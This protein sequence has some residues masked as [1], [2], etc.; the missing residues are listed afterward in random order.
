MLSHDIMKQVA[1][2]AMSGT[3]RQVRHLQLYD[4]LRASERPNILAIH[5][6]Q[7]GLPHDAYQHATVAAQEA[8]DVFA[9]AE[10]HYYSLMAL[11]HARPGEERRASLLHVINLLDL[12]DRQSDSLQYIPE[13][14]ALC[15]EAGDIHGVVLCDARNIFIELS[16]RSRPFDSLWADIKKILSSTSDLHENPAT[17]TAVLRV[18]TFSHTYTSDPTQLQEIFSFIER[19]VGYLPKEERA[20]GLADLG[21]IAAYHDPDRAMSICDEAVYLASTAGTPRLYNRCLSARGS[22][23]M[24]S[25]DYDGAL[26]DFDSAEATVSSG[27][28]NILFRVYTNRACIHY[29]RG[30]WEKGNE[31][32]NK[33][34]SCS[35]RENFLPLLNKTSGLIM[36]GLYEEAIRICRTVLSE[37][38]SFGAAWIELAARSMLGWALLESNRHIEATEQES[39]IIDLLST[40]QIVVSDPSYT[41]IF[42]AKMQI[43]RADLNAARFG[44]E[45]ELNSG[46]YCA[47]FG[48]CRMKIELAK[49]VRETDSDLAFH[50][51]R[52]A[53]TDAKRAGS[54]TLEKQA[55][56][57][58]HSISY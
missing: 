43:W 56:Q 50:Y 4:A 3:I 28:S 45:T 33:A 13:C 38:E 42:R 17:V 12:L 16:Q 8:Q 19:W 7:A 15:V 14:R 36:V 21:V 47:L 10:A 9:Y 39:K 26:Q 40:Q 37:N 34:I 48:R 46:R 53:L 20:A 1:Y 54:T 49:V 5:C 30:E 51:A 29:G 11:E 6:D 31:E 27:Y 41:V 58:L 52:S 25:G 57:V 44:L 22:A 55:N 18:A 35:S 2:G 23:R 32:T 24:I